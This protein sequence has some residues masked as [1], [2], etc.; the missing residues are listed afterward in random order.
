VWD[1]A[2]ETL[3]KATL[4]NVGMILTIAPEELPSY[5]NA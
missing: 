5:E 2:E 1:I 3:D 4:W